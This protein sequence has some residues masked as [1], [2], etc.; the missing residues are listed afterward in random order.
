MG[1]AERGVISFLER[2]PEIS[3]R[4]LCKHLRLTEAVVRKLWDK[5][6]REMGVDPIPRKIRVPKA[7]IA[8]LKQ[9]ERGGDN[10]Q[11]IEG[12]E[13]QKVDERAG[14]DG[15]VSVDGDV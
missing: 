15:R 2:E 5:T 11:R 7:Y 4:T 3:I 8:A 13:V 9:L 12:E 1:T 6:F 10:G 14:A